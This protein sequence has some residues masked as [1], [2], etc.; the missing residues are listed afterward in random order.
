MYTLA[1][2]LIGYW[3]L[4]IGIPVPGFGAGAI[5]NPDGNLA[6]Y[7]DQLLLSG[8]T[9]KENWDPEGLLSTLPAIGTTLI[10]I[11]T[12][13]MLMAEKESESSRTLQFFIWGFVLITIGYIWSWVFP[14]NKNIWTSSYALFTGGLAMFIFGLCYWFLDVKE[15][16]KFT[17]WGVAFGINAIT[18]FFLSGIIGRLL[19][20]IKFNVGETTYTLKGWL[21]DVLFSSIASP[22]NASLLYA[23]SWILLFYLLATWMMKKKIIIKV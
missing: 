5:D 19:Y 6:A 12:G 21:Y 22:V 13:R 15:K 2:L 18:V 4:M 16:Q 7:I 3:I 23:I 17:D 20:L 11:W 14:I 10:G 9:W 8:H 1:G